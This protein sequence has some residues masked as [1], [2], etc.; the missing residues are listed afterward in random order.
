VTP[1]AVCIIHMETRNTDF[2]VEL[3]NQ[4]WTVFR[5]VPQN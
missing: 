3:E 4:G 2:L 1:F 5:F